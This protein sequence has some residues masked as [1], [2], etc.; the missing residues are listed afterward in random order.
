M[1]LPYAWVHCNGSLSLRIS[2]QCATDSRSQHYYM[3]I[4]IL[5]Y[6]I[7]LAIEALAPSEFICTY[8]GLILRFAS[9]FIRG[10][11]NALTDSLRN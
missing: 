6:F 3:Y 11:V 10:D 4:L 9:Q 2:N 5:N 8:Q 1:A 7:V